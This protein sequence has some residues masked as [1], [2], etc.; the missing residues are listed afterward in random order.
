M[1]CCQTTPT[2]PAAH[3]SWVVQQLQDTYLNLH[4]V[5]CYLVFR[6]CLFIVWGSFLCNVC[7]E[8]KWGGSAFRG[9]NTQTNKQ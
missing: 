4:T 2:G 8:F 5:N 7:D 1:R 3:G 6:Y 9:N